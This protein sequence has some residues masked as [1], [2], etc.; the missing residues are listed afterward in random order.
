MV[1]FFISILFC[2]SF[3]PSSWA[4]ALQMLPPD[5]TRMELEALFTELSIKHPGYYRYQEKPSFDLYVDSVL[6]TITN[7]LSEIELLRK[8]KPVI[9]KIGC[10]HTGISLSDQTE[11]ELNRN[12]NCLPFSLNYRN[13]KAI[14]WTLFGEK[15]DLQV[16]DEVKEI[17]GQKISA[18]YDRLLASIPMDGYNETGK[19][20][21]LQYTFSQWYRSM[22]EVANQF[23]LTLGNNQKVIVQG[24][25]NTEILSYQDITNAP[26]S[27]QIKDQV[28]MIKIPSF[29]NSY[30]KS[31]QQKF[32]KVFRSYWKEIHAKK[33]KTL[34]LDLRGNTGGSDSNAAWLSSFFFEESYSYWDR[35]EVT[36]PIAK[37]VSGFNRIFYGKPKQEDG[38]WLWSTKGLLSKEFK[39]TK[40]QKPAKKSFRGKVFLLTDGLCMSSC[41]DFV[42]IMKYNQKAQ[43]IG[44][45]TGG[46]YQGNTSGLIPSEYLECGLVV[47]VPLLKYVNAIDESINFG[48]GTI[49]DLELYPSLEEIQNDELFLNR[50]LEVVK[51]L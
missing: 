47:D 1:R 24:V 27:M 12:P 28:A 26:I 13:G 31:H 3:S 41:A 34:V 37:D 51:R 21:L 22:I 50:I 39:F 4:Q 35:I 8:V 25:F 15:S 18:I 45:E 11:T 6:Q 33:I 44:E 48:R 38:T 36:P 40:L 32:K 7:P 30:L 23:E 16:G 14:I 46:G 2:V 43:V 10:L 29:A 19:Y 20:R 49:P 42:A 9:A 17:N 5:S